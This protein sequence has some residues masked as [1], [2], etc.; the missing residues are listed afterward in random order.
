MTEE[1]QPDYFKYA[2]EIGFS[3]ATEEFFYEDENS[4]KTDVKRLFMQTSP[5]SPIGL[6]SDITQIDPFWNSLWGYIRT[7]SWAF[8]GERSDLND[9]ISIIVAIT[10][11]TTNN[12]SSSLLT[13]E[14]PLTHL[15]GT[16]MSCEI[17]SRL[18][19]FERHNLMI[20]QLSEETELIVK[21][22]LHASFLSAY[23]MDNVLQYTDPHIPNFSS[24]REKAEKIAIYLD[25]G[26][27]DN[28]HN[29][30]AR[31]KPF[32]GW[33][34]S[35]ESKISVFEFDL[36]VV[37]KLKSLFYDSYTP[38]KLDGI[39]KKIIIT[40]GLGNAVNLMKL[41]KGFE[42]LEHL[43]G[44]ES[45]HEVIPIEDRFF[46]FGRQ[47][48]ICID[49]DCGEKSFKSEVN[50]IKLRNETERSVLFPTM[51][52]IWNDKINGE[53][54]EK[55]V[56]DIFVADSNVRWVK[57]VGSGTQADGGR[58][59]EVEMVFKKQIL[60]DSNEPPYE[61]KKILVQCKAYQQNVNKNNVQ[62]IRDTIDMH[63]ADGYYLVVSSQIT[64]QLHEYLKSLRDRGLLVDWWNR[65]D[66]EDKL[67]VHPEI[68]KR[69]PDIIQVV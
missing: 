53:R 21:K 64:R 9:L 27:D 11:R 23:I 38:T 42:L 22:I 1:I 59:L 16:D 34:R 7:S 26:Y 25:G 65:E 14:H 33:F 30:M 49:D 36:T 50:E 66:I 51:E 47:H 39:T 19:S 18:I 61:M 69:Y 35:F 12:I 13:Q 56:R 20:F 45:Q 31:S 28:K 4:K 8:D 6:R 17:H 52:F 44:R 58:D 67:R 41:D 15:Y 24:Y 62:D 10:L 57:R 32:W 2:K 48:V 37:N 29:F 43:E 60:V 46:I 3:V 55:L 63:R 68:A 54:F 5:Q 40:N